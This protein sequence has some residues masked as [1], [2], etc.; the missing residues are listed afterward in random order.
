MT[1]KTIRYGDLELDRPVAVVGFPGAGLVSS[2][3]PNYLVSQ[4]EME[5]LLGFASPEMPPYCLVAGGVAMPPVRM[6]GRKGDGKRGRDMVVVMSEYAPKPEDCYDLSNCILDHLRRMGC[7]TVVCLEGVP[8]YNE[9]DGMVVCHSGENSEKLARKTGLPL[10]TGGMLRGMTGVIMYAAPS[11][12]M[13][14]VSL[15]AP[16]NQ[17]LPDPGAASTF[18]APLKKMIP[19]LKVD[20]KPLLDEAEQMQKRVEEQSSQPADTVQYYG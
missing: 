15:V 9:D 20:S 13:D 3:A 18:I 17:N 10:M 12:G 5:P 14:V 16:A 6:Y 2:I 8:R 11:Y 4:M 1:I 7:D 19:G